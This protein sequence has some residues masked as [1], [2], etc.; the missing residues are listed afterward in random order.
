MT[1]ARSGF[2]LVIQPGDVIMVSAPPVQGCPAEVL[3][4]VQTESGL[5]GLE[6]LFDFPA[7]AG[8]RDEGA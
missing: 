5:R 3:V 2:G 7:T 6:R 1:V 4:L 8:N